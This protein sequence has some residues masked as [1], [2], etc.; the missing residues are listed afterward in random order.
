MG[1]DLQEYFNF[2]VMFWFFS[3]FSNFRFGSFLLRLAQH[4]IPERSDG[5]AFLRN[6]T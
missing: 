2:N 6:L 4:S 1:I 5:F 3:Y